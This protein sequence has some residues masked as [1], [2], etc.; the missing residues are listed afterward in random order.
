MSHEILKFEW[1]R[2][3]L[4]R[5]SWYTISRGDVITEEELIEIIIWLW[6]I[7]GDAHDTRWTYMKSGG[8]LTLVDIA[9]WKRVQLEWFDTELDSIIIED[10]GTRNH[11]ANIRIST[12]DESRTIKKWE[13]LNPILVELLNNSK[14][15]SKSKWDEI[16]L[17]LSGGDFIEEKESL[18]DCI[19][20]HMWDFSTIGGIDIDGC[21]PEISSLIDLEQIL[22][23]TSI[24]T[25][26]YTRYK[27]TIDDFIE[28]NA[29]SGIEITEVTSSKLVSWLWT[30]DNK[31]KLLIAD[32]LLSQIF[33]KKR[34][35]KSIAKHLDL[36]L[37][38]KPW[39]YV[40]HREHGIALFYAVIKKKLWEIEREYLELH[41][42]S[43]DKLFVPLT[44]IYRVSRYIGENNPE[45]TRLTWTEWEKTMQKTNEE[46]EA[47]AEDILETSAKRTLAKGKAFWVFR[48][49]ERRFQ[50]AFAY[51][52]TVDQ[53]TAIDEIFADMESE[54]PMDRL[55][56]GDVWFGKTEVAMNAI[57]KAVLSGM[58]VAVLSPLLVL[59]DEHYETFCERLSPFGVRVA[60]LTRMSNPAEI[61]NTLE[62]MSQG[63]IDVVVG[64]HRLISDDIRWKKLGLL[65]IDEE[66]KFWVT[67]KE[68]IKKI[69][70]GLDILSLSATPIPRSLN[71]ALSGLKKISILTTPPK[72]KKPIE[73]IVIRWNEWVILQ[74]IQ[75]ELWR[76]GQ[77]II[78]HNRIRG[79]ES[80]EKE[81]ENIVKSEKW[82]MKNNEEELNEW[83]M[84]N[85]KWKIE[86][87]SDAPLIRGGG[88][89]ISEKKYNHL[90]YNPLLTAKAQENRKQMNDPE[91]KFWYDILKQ[92]SISGYKF[93]KQKPI[94]EYIVDFYC[95]ELGLVIEIDGDS[96]IESQEYDTYRTKELENLGLTVI[97]YNNH[98][99]IV[100]TEWVLLDLIREI[101]QIRKE[102]SLRHP[103]GTPPSSTG[104][105]GH[106][107]LSGE[108]GGIETKNQAIGNSN[109]QPRII[110]THG[111][112]PGEQIE[113]R[114]HGFK[115]GEYNI[116][117]TTTIIENWVNF[118]SANTIIIIDPEEF[119]L[120]S[121]HQL[122]GRVWRKDIEWRCYL[123]YRKPE[124]NWDEKE[125]LITIANNTHLGA[126]F[127]IA[128]RDMEIRGAWDVLG[129]K[130]A[131]K[132]KDIWLTL[133]F[134]LLEEKVEELKNARKTKKWTKIE[135]EISY[136]IPDSYF[137]S[138]WDKLHFYREIENIE[139]LE[140]LEEIESEMIE[141]C[142]PDKGGGSAV[143]MQNRGVPVWKA[144]QTPPPPLSGGLI[145]QI[146]PTHPSVASLHPS[147]E[148]TFSE[149]QQHPNAPTPQRPNIS[150][151]FLL[152]R[153]RMKLSEYGVQK[154]SKVWMNYTFDFDEST[155]VKQIRD[156]LDRFDTKKNYVL[157]WARKIRVETRFYKNNVHFLE[158]LS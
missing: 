75:Q 119:W 152:L 157:L 154:L 2:I 86:L 116:L 103:E 138:E 105:V 128:M 71:L 158:S 40:V 124:I 29:I 133:Y 122:R 15:E 25:H 82:K 132:S 125:R 20:I 41:Y 131:G 107:P 110:I 12:K 58:Q 54:L 97:R 16:L 9:L 6:Y 83:R 65:I 24:S 55:V 90:P 7:H 148:F 60:I 67:H 149:W 140:E 43:G 126:G 23:D 88:G 32:D 69:K 99:V 150:N 102:Q 34:S 127:E 4:E 79:M 87:V 98:E 13:K 115:K 17:V 39:D 18:L 147:D 106:L 113:D 77:V 104:T 51:E 53:K 52:Y 10:N 62:A 63:R 156:F 92:E 96:H 72:R 31:R 36:L 37:T 130:Q 94:L 135:L 8:T 100:N 145:E 57:F 22:R 74:A 91:K 73:T 38:L 120:A 64:T 66:H 101:E 84:K 134:R 137:A 117:L 42:A 19:D 49:D 80:I 155:N 121:L 142:P 28:Y 76:G 3:H 44:E 46:I 1:N 78:I 47:I 95:A 50:E 56:S 93:T 33:V 153:V 27:K 146:L 14:N 26:V 30:L 85:R 151:L 61:R 143:S 11:I 111:Q 144:K 81:I 89:L 141:I 118:L 108:Q 48:E 136:I 5:G 59:A 45:L 35:K 68:K 129:I 109:Q 139:S 21:I 114:I 70:S 112:M 123:M